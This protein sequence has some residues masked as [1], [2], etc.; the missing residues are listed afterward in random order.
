M[1]IKHILLFIIAILSIK[2][3]NGQNN[4]QKEILWTADWSPNGKYIAVAGNVNA[5]NIYSATTFE[6]H[7]SWP[8]ANT[9]SNV[10]WHPT[11]N[12]IAVLTHISS[13]ESFLLN[14]DTNEKTRLLD[15]CKDGARAM[16]WNAKGDMF[17][18]GDNDGQILLYDDTGKLIK[19]IKNENGLSITGLDW[20]PTKA[21]FTIV[22][23]KIRTYD[24]D[25]KLLMSI[26]NRPEDV[27]MLCVAW[28]PSGNFFVTGDYGDQE[29]KSLL[30]FW[31]SDGKLLQ[32]IDNSKGEYRNIAW[33]KKGNRLAT[34]SDAL[35]IWDSKGK[36]VAEG[37]SEDLLWG[38]SW[39]KKGNR[40]VTS[41]IEE[42]ILL[43]NN[44]AKIIKTI[45]Q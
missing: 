15:I 42:R 35:R 4:K 2:T 45:H 13:E 33:N 40:I 29:M 3:I 9:I 31:A 32:S 28:H 6:I 21:V 16:D 20:H 22:S 18:I 25:G 30:Q 19:K 36:L 14:L 12:M 24:T 26:K 11:K 8:V 10:K 23:D 5:L 1:K 39:N 41:S 34:A 44:K 27:L 37:A 7:K 43:W 38:I 17:A